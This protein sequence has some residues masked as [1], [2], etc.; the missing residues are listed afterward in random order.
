MVI[1][2]KGPKV[3]RKKVTVLPFF[4]LPFSQILGVEHFLENFEGGGGHSPPLNTPLHIIIQRP[5]LSSSLLYKIHLRENILQI[6]IYF[7][8][9][10]IECNDVE[11]CRVDTFVSRFQVIFSDQLLTRLFW[12][13]G[14]KKLYMPISRSIS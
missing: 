7:V 14:I 13:Q 5:A 3:F 4:S 10:T 1:V 2:C 9:D 12:C 8:A 11:R 6:L